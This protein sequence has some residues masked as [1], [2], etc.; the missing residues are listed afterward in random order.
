MSYTLDFDVLLDD[1]EK[2]QSNK[3]SGMTFHVIMKVKGQ[4]NG[5]K[6]IVFNHICLQKAIPLAD[7]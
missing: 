5:L 1:S 2:V 6:L 3:C 7:V 4:V